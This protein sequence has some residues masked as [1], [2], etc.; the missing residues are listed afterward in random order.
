MVSTRRLCGLGICV[1][2]FLLTR[3]Y[4]GSICQQSWYRLYLRINICSLSATTLKPRSSGVRHLWT[5]FRTRWYAPVNSKAIGLSGYSLLERQLTRSILEGDDC[6]VSGI[7][8][9]SSPGEDCSAP[10]EGIFK[11]HSRYVCFILQD[12]IFDNALFNPASR[13]NG[14]EWSDY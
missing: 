13:T 4:S 2:R 6:I 12:R 3:F 7:Y 9:P 11:N 10:D 8:F 5:I 1:S 14:N